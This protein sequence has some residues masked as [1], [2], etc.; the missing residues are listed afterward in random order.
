MVRFNESPQQVWKRLMDY[1]ESFTRPKVAPT[2]TPTPTPMPKPTPKPTPEPTATPTLPPDPLS[3]ILEHKDRAPKEVTLIEAAEF[4]VVLNG[5]E[6]GSAQV[7]AGSKVSVIKIDPKTIDVVFQGGGKRVPHDATNIRELAKL[8]MAKPE[9]TP[10]ISRVPVPQ[11]TPRAPFTG[12]GQGPGRGPNRGFVH[13]GIPLTK[14]DLE[15]LK[16]NV[17]RQPW[18]TGYEQL[19]ND[20]HSKLDYKMLGP[21]A[22]V[23]RN[24]NVNLH[25]WRNDMIAVWNLARMWYFTGNAD[26]AQKAH[27]ILLAWAT[28]QTSF[29]GMEANLDLGDHAFRYVGGAEILHGT[30]PGWTQADTDAVKSLFLNVYWRPT[31]VGIHTLG[32]GNKGGLSLSAAT[33][34]A[35]FCDDHAKFNHALEMW[36][37]FPS[38][39]FANTLPNGEHG[40]TGRDQGHSYGQMLAMAFTAEMFWKQ[41]IDMFAELDNR[42]LAMGE[43]YA[44]FNLGVTTPFVPMGTTDE[45]YLTIWDKPG[46][47]AEPQA[48]NIMKSAYVLRKGMSAPYLEQKLAL[49]GVNMDAFMFLKSS[50]NSVATAPAPITLPSASPVGT[51]GLTNRDIGGA[52]PAGSGTCSNGMW[53]VSGAGTDIWTHGSEAFHYL[54]K[55]VTGD[56]AMIAKVTSVQNTGGLDKAGVMIRSDLN[57]TPACKA[58]VALRPDSRVETYFHGWSEMY[59][60]SNWESQSYPISQSSWWIKVER[61]GNMVTTYASPDGTSWAT[62]VVGTF[63]KMPGT[64]YIG[65]CVTSLANGTLNTSTFTNVCVTGGTGGAVTI[66]AAPLAVYASPGDAQVPLRWLESFGAESY[67]VKRAGTKGGPYRLV[68]SV[69]GT[70]YIDT[71]VRN[72]ETYYYAVSAVNSAGESSNSPED[73]VKPRGP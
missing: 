7:P 70:S 24:P 48:F 58:W 60:G 41:G 36:R 55:K 46:Y 8:E 38:T 45:Y 27:D 68:A 35:I 66:P 18:K 4:P 61:L 49:Q 23:S 21:C 57:A 40:E 53:T 69:K 44:R 30:W 59:G 9:P 52:T 42:I 63:D 11:A 64:A 72:G 71:S 14:E 62:L 39:G 3:W 65:L 33:A 56:C 20:G 47:P 31:G 73:T 51:A 34:I 22:T 19:V 43:Y 26:Y 32:P 5:K 37:T 54:Y 1:V 28:T 67:N 2:P 10:A 25:Q 6:V 16:H 15:E 12:F 50:D 13:P 29:G 17:K